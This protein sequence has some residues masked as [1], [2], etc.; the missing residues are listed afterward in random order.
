MTDAELNCYAQQIVDAVQDPDIYIKANVAI[1]RE[2]AAR[3]RDRL[4]GG[5]GRP[6]TAYLRSVGWPR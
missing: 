6:D 2:R 5:I 3:N 4:L 1:A